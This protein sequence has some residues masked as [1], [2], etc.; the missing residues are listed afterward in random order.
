M[1]D[2]DS[3]TYTYTATAPPTSSETMVT[4]LPLDPDATTVT[5]LNG[6]EDDDGT[7]GP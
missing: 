3:R 1:E 5:T 7:V 6:V 4:A 2:F